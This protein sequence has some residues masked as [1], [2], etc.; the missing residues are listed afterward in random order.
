MQEEAELA[1]APEP[2]SAQA[3]V[4]VAPA[5]RDLLVAVADALDSGAEKTAA[6]REAVENA[7]RRRCRT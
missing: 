2:S 3:P 6:A 4:N 1:V 7:V 5:V